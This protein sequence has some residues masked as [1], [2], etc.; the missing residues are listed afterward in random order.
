MVTESGLEFNSRMR[1]VIWARIML[2]EG[3]CVINFCSFQ[4]GT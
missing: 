2:Y 1:Q 3:E 4:A